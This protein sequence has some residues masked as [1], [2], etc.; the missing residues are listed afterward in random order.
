MNKIEMTYYIHIILYSFIFLHTTIRNVQVI[1]FK[2]QSEV[3]Y[4]IYIIHPCKF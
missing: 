4:D 1:D 2:L 3:V